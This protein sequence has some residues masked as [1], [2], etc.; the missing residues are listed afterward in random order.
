MIRIKLGRQEGALIDRAEQIYNAWGDKNY[1]TDKI[2]AFLNQE[3]EIPQAGQVV[4]IYPIPF[5]SWSMHKVPAKRKETMEQVKR[6]AT[7]AYGN[8]PK[9]W[10]GFIL[11]KHANMKQLTL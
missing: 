7:P 1:T 3:F 4:T 10:L 8:S 2:E 11:E 6:R 9:K 5:V